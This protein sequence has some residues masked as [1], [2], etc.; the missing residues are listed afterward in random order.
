MTKDF[1]AK[2]IHYGALNTKAYRY[3][4]DTRHDL[5]HQYQDIS[6]TPLI[7][8]GTTDALGPWEIVWSDKDKLSSYSD[9]WYTVKGQGVLVENGY[10]LRGTKRDC[11]GSEVT[12]Y[13][14]KSD[15]RGGYD[16]TDVTI[17]DFI[18]GKGELL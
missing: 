13:I 7:S 17:L 11:N 1:I 14:Y 2:V 18:A 10:V 9:G 3:K 6:R 15:G 4:L 8:L 16:K 5:Y 12:A